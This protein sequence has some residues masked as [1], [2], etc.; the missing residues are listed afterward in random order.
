MFQRLRASY[1][2][3]LFIHMPR[4][5]A[6]LLGKTASALFEKGKLIL[7]KDPAFQREQW[8]HREGGGTIQA[9]VWLPGIA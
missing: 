6:R 9:L 3:E 5:L 4:A 7:C 2:V 1:K 8:C